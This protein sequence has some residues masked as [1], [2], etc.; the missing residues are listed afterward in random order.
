[1]LVDGYRDSNTEDDQKLVGEFA[2]FLYG[3]NLPKKTRSLSGNVPVYGSNGIIGT[4]DQALTIGPTIV[5]GRKGTIGTTHYSPIPCWPIDTTFYLTDSDTELLRFKYYSLKTLSLEMMNGDSAVPGLNRDEVH[6]CVLRVPREDEQRVISHILGTLDDKIELNRRMNETLE[7]MAQAIFKDWFVDFGPVHAKMRSHKAYLT[8][9][10]WRLFPN[11]IGKENR[12]TGWKTHKLGEFVSLT[13][14]SSYKSADLQDSDTALVTLKSFR[15][16]GGYREDGLKP[17]TGKYK[18]EQ[19]IAP[20]E[21]VMALTDVT[22]AAEVIGKPAIVPENVQYRTLVASL[23]VGIVRLNHENIGQSFVF[24]L[25]QTPQFQN[26]AYSYCTGTTVL[27]LNKDALLSFEACIP[28][29]KILP[30]FNNIGDSISAKIFANARENALLARVR[31]LLIP[32]LISGEIR[33]AGT[34]EEVRVVT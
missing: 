26:H 17:Y 15:R 27:H 28:S 10:I 1:M 20:G 5:I 23:D 7:A 6:Q 33:L 21:L 29:G 32:K 11:S 19:I 22:Q 24:H 4:H 30:L 8:P 13:K 18:V 16:G 25:L 9:E 3:K 12:P 2:P 31:D 34:Q 14:G